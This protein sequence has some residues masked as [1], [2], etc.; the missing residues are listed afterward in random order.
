MRR[1][2][3][4][5]GFILFRTDGQQMIKVETD[6]QLITLPRLMTHREFVEGQEG[7]TV[8]STKKECLLF[9]AHFDLIKKDAS[10]VQ[11]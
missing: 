5:P 1:G 7:Y 2:F 4:K 3:L 10:T 8:Y 6:E 9:P 11:G